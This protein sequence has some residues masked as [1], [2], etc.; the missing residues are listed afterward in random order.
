VLPN[1]VPLI[2]V[3]G[4]TPESIPDWIGGGVDGFGLGGGL[5]KPGQDTE[6]TLAKARAYVA[7][8]RR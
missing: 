8:V 4:V 3:G 2:V 1:D 6:T 7:A 5:Y